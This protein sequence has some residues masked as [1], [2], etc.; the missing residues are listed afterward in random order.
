MGSTYIN[1]GY[2]P[3]VTIGAPLALA[4][5]EVFHP[6]PPHDLLQLNYRLWLW[7]HYLQIPLFPLSALAMAVLIRG[8]RGFSASLARV[9][10]FV[11]AIAYTGELVKAA[12]ASTNP[13]SWRPAI[14]A[15]WNHSVIGGSPHGAPALAVIGTMAWLVAGLSAAI[16][17]RRAG[18]S[19]GPV[20]VI[21]FSALP[22]LIFKTHAWP[23]GPVT[24][25]SLAIGAAWLL[26]DRRS[27]STLSAVNR[28]ATSLST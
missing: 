1:R 3:F 25:G 9:A 11:F 17:L 5:L 24:F 2:D 8:V 20:I 23:G 10:L 18:A 27:R 22:L 21:A 19:L 12:H 28:Q 16:A 4:V 6:H 26:L 15:V 13:E 7:I 14:D